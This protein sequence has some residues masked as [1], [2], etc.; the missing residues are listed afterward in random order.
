MTENSDQINHSNEW[1]TKRQILAQRL[2][3]QGS[4]RDLKFYMRQMEYSSKKQLIADIKSVSI[5]LRNNN[6]LLKLEPARCIACG[7]IFVYKKNEIKIPSKCPKC[8]QQRIEWP[9]LRLT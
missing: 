3:E 5:S 8:R 4:I 2:V 9:S 7:Y 1:K 6:K